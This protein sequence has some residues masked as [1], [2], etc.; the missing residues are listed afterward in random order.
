MKN[1]LWTLLAVILLSSC[2]NQPEADTITAA[3]VTSEKE[4]KVNRIISLNGT[5]TELIYELGLE[6]ELV[7]VDRTS[8]Y[9]TTAT[10]LPNLG[11]MRQ[12]NAEAILALKPTAILV[13]EENQDNAVLKQ[14]A[15]AGI[16]IKGIA[17]PQTLTGVLDVAEQLS[18]VLEK[19]FDTAKLAEKV[20]DNE[21]KLKAFLAEKEEKPKVLFIYARGANMTM[22]AGKNTFAEKMIELAGGTHIMHEFESFKPLTPEALLAQQPEVILMFD[23]GLAS[24]T[25]EEENKTAIDG[26]LAIQGMA[27]TP[28]GKNK[29]VIA[30][31]GL[32]LSGFGPRASEAA[33]E[34]AQK[35]HNN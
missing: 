19:E 25:N 16:T 2:S 6:S 28:A 21:T 24:L 4:E 23:S 29:R 8:V 18:T 11:H 3:A 33:L 5:I 20:Q 30:M 26:L 14:M 13:D 32:Y 34:L 9:P 10:K 12:L 22:V 27:E 15:E 35:I 1:I 31:D 7:G 17:V